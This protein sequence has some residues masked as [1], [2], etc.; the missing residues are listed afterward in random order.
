VRSSIHK[1]LILRLFILCFCVFFFSGVVISQGV[2]IGQWRHHLP[3][4]PIIS[5][6][7]TPEKIIGA[8]PYGLLIYNLNDN[9]VKKFNKVHGLSDFDI[10][11]IK[12]AQKN[13]ALFI[14][15]E[16]G[17]IDIKKNN[18]VYNIPSI[19]RASIIG[20][21]RI[22]SVLI[23][24]NIAYLA[25]GFGIVKLNISDFTIRDTYY[26]GPEGS[27]IQVNDLL[28]TD[29]YFYAATAGGI[30]KA[31]ID[32]PN[33]ADF[34]YWQR[35]ENL[36]NLG[37][38]GNFN[39]ILSFD[40][41]IFVNMRV[42]DNE[43]ISDTLYYHEDDMWN[44]FK[45][46][47]EE[48]Y[49]QKKRQIRVSRNH[50]LIASESYVD[51]FDKFFN[52]VQHIDNFYNGFPNPYDAMIDSNGFTWIGDDYHGIVKMRTPNSSR[53]IRLDGPSSSNS[54]AL[55]SSPGN[56]WIAPSNLSGQN[57]WNYNGFF[58]FTNERW[59]N[60][61]RFGYEEMERFFDIVNVET[62]P[63]NPKRVVTCS[64]YDGIITFNDREFEA[65][66]NDE[67]STLK[68]RLIGDPRVR[69]SSAKFD[70]AGNLWVV[71]S[72]VEEPLSVLKPDKEWMS[73]SFKGLVPSTSFTDDMIIDN[74][75][76]KWIIMRGEQFH[77]GNGIIVFKENTLNNNMDY[78]VK[79]ITTA[80]G[81]GGLPSNNVTAITKDNNGYIWVATDKGVAVFYSPQRALTGAPF[82]AQPI[83][84]EEDRFAGLLFENE[85]VNA[86]TVDG[87]NKKWFGTTRAGAFLMAAD[88]R[89]TIR[90]FDNNN[91][92]IPSN[93]VTDIAI[94]PK[95]GEVFF[96]TDRGVA[97]FRG[98]ATEGVTQHSDVYA[99]PNPV[100]P[101]YNGYIA[102]NGLVSNANVKIT[103]IN[104]NLIYET[105]AEGGQAIWDGKNLRGERPGSGVYMVFSTNEDGNETAVTKILFL[106]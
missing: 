11:V 37:E 18:T 47:G 22:N 69:V 48:E 33:F 82:N 79:H 104:G 43:E 85:T 45:P 38:T 94:E 71:N 29:S 20:S 99:F 95:T 64:W 19:K 66:Y 51:V 4:N 77:Q 72:Q 54:F 103:D 41:R 83:I 9:S 70:N 105:I 90:H 23:E 88:G 32:A 49:F 14:A 58:R 36:P 86:I 46:K 89:S 60:F 74:F 26:I 81:R 31:D 30:F 87:S 1:Y 50:L 17:N 101:N 73:F 52:K 67:N 76:Q 59:Q 97:S 39:Y 96:A 56:V 98:Y 78:K 44:I 27:Q 3:S 12:Y 75:G 57:S 84:L 16:N 42:E 93:N 63:R 62:D 6:V 35:M 65:K 13:D 61:N 21:K 68:P 53:K 34:N 10:S 55:A 28:I 92:P 25:T 2:P 102:I 15:Y 7:E 91:S 106:N 40:N 8:N 24:D 5:I 100:K 80:D